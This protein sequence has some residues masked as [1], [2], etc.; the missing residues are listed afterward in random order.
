ML[1]RPVECP[2]LQV[3][4]V[5]VTV[6]VNFLD[7]VG[8]V[9]FFEVGSQN[10]KYHRIGGSTASTTSASSSATQRRGNNSCR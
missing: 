8:A 7:V 1:S 3:L 2:M 10:L 5:V 4:R 9:A 6:T